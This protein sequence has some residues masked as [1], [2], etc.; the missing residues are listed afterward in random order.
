MNCDIIRSCVQ[1]KKTQTHEELSKSQ[2]QTQRTLAVTTIVIGLLLIITGALLLSLFPPVLTHT[3]L[4]AVTITSGIGV[5]ALGISMLC[6]CFL[7]KIMDD[8]SSHQQEAMLYTTKQE[9]ID[10]EKTIQSLTCEFNAANALEVQLKN[11][12][13]DLHMNTSHKQD[14]LEEDIKN[15]EKM[16]V[17]LKEKLSLAEKTIM[18]LN[19]EN[20]LFKKLLQESELELITSSLEA[21][22][23]LNKQIMILEKKIEDQD[24]EI[25]NLTNQLYDAEKTLKEYMSSLENLQITAQTKIQ[26]LEN[27]IFLA[28]KEQETLATKLSEQQ[29]L[30]LNLKKEEDLLSGQL[31]KALDRLTLTEQLNTL[32]KRRKHNF[33]I[34]KKIDDLTKQFSN[35][36]PEVHMENMQKKEAITSKLQKLKQNFN[37]DDFKQITLSIELNKILEDKT[38]LHIEAKDNYVSMTLEALPVLKKLENQIEC[39]KLQS[40]NQEIEKA[41]TTM[42]FLEELL[43]TNSTMINESLMEVVLNTFIQDEEQLNQELLISTDSLSQCHKLLTIGKKGS[44]GTIILTEEQIENIFAAKKSMDGLLDTENFIQKKYL[45]LKQLTTLIQTLIEKKEATI[46]AEAAY[47]MASKEL[48]DVLIQL[49]SD[50]K[51][52]YTLELELMSLLK[53]ITTLQTQY[54]VAEEQLL[55]LNNS[56]VPEPK[57]WVKLEQ[58]LEKLEQ[59]VKKQRPLDD[60]LVTF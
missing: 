17:E 35:F 23:F 46:R 1:T 39:L 32:V 10:F 48:N 25:V 50:Q 6:R 13:K 3:I 45:S 2:K 15:N 4:S 38:K 42:I 43:D 9:G 52:T 47:K 19:E 12:L 26:E 54:L 60:D 29:Q 55:E 33:Q 59:E 16:I 24:Q 44:S 49:T 18:Q 34:Q 58:R 36:Y 8:L 5:I 7:P 14:A 56:L 57:E 51:L 11:E 53:D 20:I 28:E 21:E 41:M 37:D 30:H 27:T 40:Y 31:S 22:V